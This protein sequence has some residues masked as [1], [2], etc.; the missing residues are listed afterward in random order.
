MIIIDFAGSTPLF[1]SVCNDHKAVVKHAFFPGIEQP[2]ES[3]NLGGT[4]TPVA[5]RHRG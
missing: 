3:A 4:K 5:T 2:H 1:W